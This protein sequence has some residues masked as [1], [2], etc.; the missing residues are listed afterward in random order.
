MSSR[1]WSFFFPKGVLQRDCQAGL[2]LLLF[3]HSLEIWLLLTEDSEQ[4]F[5]IS[6]QISKQLKR[7]GLDWSFGVI[8]TGRKEAKDDC[9]F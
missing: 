3:N 2:S 1:P 8:S 9:A 5:G 6:E 7:G 4:N